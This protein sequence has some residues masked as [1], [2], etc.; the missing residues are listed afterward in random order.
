MGTRINLLL[1]HDL[2]D[3]RD[4]REILT[5][6]DATTEATVAVSEY[7]LASEPDNYRPP[8]RSWVAIP[9]SPRRPGP[10]CF[11]GPGNLLLSVTATAARVRAGGRWRG[12]L[13]I[14]PLRRAHLLA[15]RAIARTLGARFMSLHADSDAV[16]EFFL[17]GRSAWEC[18]ERMER[19]WGPPQGSVVRIEPRIIEAAELYLPSSVWFLEDIKDES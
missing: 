11:D 2:A 5:R 19:L 17:C 8:Q 4:V 9:E 15:F 12:F 13:A 3:P 1:D 6:L 16:D 14:E 18:V 10:R 7:W